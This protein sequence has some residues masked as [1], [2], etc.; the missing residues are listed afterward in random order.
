[1]LLAIPTDDFD[2]QQMPLLFMPILN[3]RNC[4][5]LIN[6]AGTSGLGLLQ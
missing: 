3:L 4:G 2:I 5:F 1:M 6:I